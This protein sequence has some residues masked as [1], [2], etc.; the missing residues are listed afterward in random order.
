[1]NLDSQVEMA[2][3]GVLVGKEREETQVSKVL[4]EPVSQ[5]QP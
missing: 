1:M 3:P 5:E 4:L 2:L